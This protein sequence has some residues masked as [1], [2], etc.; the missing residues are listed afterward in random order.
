[1]EAGWRCY[2]IGQR[3][4]RSR[5]WHFPSYWQ[6]QQRNGIAVHSHVAVTVLLRSM[7]HA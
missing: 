1:M 2:N 6:L 4:E 5:E 7:I 3:L